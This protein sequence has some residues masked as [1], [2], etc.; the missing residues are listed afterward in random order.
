MNQRNQ[1][2]Q[3]YPRPQPPRLRKDL[4]ISELLDLCSAPLSKEERVK[5]LKEQAKIY[6]ELKYFLIVAYFYTDVFKGIL[7][8]NGGLAYIPSTIVTKGASL[9]SLKSMWNQIKT[10]FDT[11]ESGFRIRRSKAQQ[12]LNRLYK[13][14]ALVVHNLFTGNY[15][16]IALN[17]SV[18]AEAFPEDIPNPN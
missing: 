10:I 8:S 13:D 1:N 18:V 16:N 17:A 5:T 12:L 2:Q 14:D 3:S 6:P 9:E 15:K 4:D 7:D 11:Y